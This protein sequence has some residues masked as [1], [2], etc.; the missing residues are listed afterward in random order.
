VV[1]EEVPALVQAAAAADVHDEH[2]ANQNE[3]IGYFAQIFVS[4]RIYYY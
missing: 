4:F 3:M 1:V 2:E